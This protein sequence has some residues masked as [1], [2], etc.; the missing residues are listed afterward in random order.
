MGFAEKQPKAASG[1]CKRPKMAKKGLKMTYS[2]LPIKAANRRKKKV[3]NAGRKRDK[4]TE[5]ET[6]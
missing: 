3:V 2:T 6:E 5:R 1:A 4:E